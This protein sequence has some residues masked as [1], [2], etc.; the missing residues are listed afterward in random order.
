MATANPK[1]VRESAKNTLE[2][3]YRGEGH[4]HRVQP[5]DVV[6][7]GGNLFSPNPISPTGD[8][9]L[10]QMTAEFNRQAALHTGKGSKLFK[11]YVI[12]LAPGETLEPHQWLEFATAYMQKLGYDN[13]TKW[14]AAAHNDTTRDYADLD[15]DT[16]HYDKVTG[17]TFAHDKH[18]KHVEITGCQHIHIMSCLVKNEPGGA[19]VKTSN[20]YEKGWS[21]MREYE[22]KFGLRQLESPDENFGYNYSKGQ[23]KKYGNRNEAAKHDEAAIIRARFKNLYETEGKPKTISK[24]VLGL[25]KRGVFVEV[26]TNNEGNVCGISY[27]LDQEGTPISG[28]RVKSTRF[29]WG[30]LIS[31]ERIDY[32]PDRDNRFL[33][34]GDPIQQITLSVR[35]NKR[36]ASRIKKLR[37]PYRVYRRHDRIWADLTFVNDRNIRN[38]LLFAVAIANML[39]MLFQ[40]LEDE[41]EL[42]SVIFESQ[43][44][45]YLSQIEVEHNPIETVTY[46]TL[47]KAKL[48]KDLDKDTAAWRENTLVD[49]I[50]IFEPNF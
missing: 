22:K 27:K 30:K 36:Q 50:F 46:Q 43:R 3:M 37:A 48:F 38:A 44:Q 17:K 9:D 24:L 21:V 26:R 31:H 42:Q 11:H 41:I 13:S 28:S 49:N 4:E 40:L 34:L 33:G 10:K 7:I 25:A 1:E 15:L 14:I 12:S 35:I 39:K 6:H 8:V 18:G 45:N 2:Y 32:N 16:L 5:G 20:D 29:S 47:D 23:I 19:L